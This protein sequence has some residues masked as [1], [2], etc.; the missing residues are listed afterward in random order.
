MNAE[1]TLHELGLPQNATKIY[2]SLL[3]SGKLSVSEIA[4]KSGVH[5]VNVYDAVKP[6]MKQNLV[7]EVKSGKKRLFMANNPEHLK[8]ILRK[9]EE[10][11]NEI[12]PALTKRFV[13]AE[14]KTQT[15]EGLEGIKQILHD[16]LDTG[17]EI[18]AFGI[19]QKMPELLAG[20][21]LTFH[22]RRIEKSI[23]IRHI[24]NENAQERI[25]HLNSIAKSKARYLPPEYSVPATTIVYGKK[26]AFWIWSEE[27]FSVL[28]ESEK[29]AGAYRKYFELLWKLAMQ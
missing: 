4:T 19:P 2:L 17:E 26:V 3:E 25:R 7:S 1:E 22:R 5:R 20:H 9:K 12:I 11:L 16:M 24:Y 10:K 15:Y 28:I 29:M 27:P 18:C 6:L 23:P 14:N 13:T 8:A 21:L